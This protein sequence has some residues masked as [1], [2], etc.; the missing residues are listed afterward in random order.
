MIQIFLAD[1]RTDQLKVVQE[2]LADLKTK[3]FFFNLANFKSFVGANLSELSDPEPPPDSD[4]PSL[5][6][7]SEFF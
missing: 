1:G 4:Y 2:V 3:D 5:L 7:L 6:R